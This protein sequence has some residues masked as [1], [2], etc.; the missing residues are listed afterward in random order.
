VRLWYDARDVPFLRE[1]EKDA[2]EIRQ[3]DAVTM[4]QLLDAGFTPESVTAAVIAEDFGILQHSN[5]Y[6]V[7]LQPPAPD[8]GAFGVLQTKALTISELVK[9]G[10]TPESVI[11]AVKA[12]DVTKLV[13]AD[14]VPR[15]LIEDPAVAGAEPGVQVLP[16]S[17]GN[18]KTPPTPP[19]LPAGKGKTP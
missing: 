12:N 1:D 2:A 17:D 19:A 15:Q 4:R 14:L 13:S 7:Q 5:L 8:A 16:G 11:E 18:G 6:S 9:A 10:Y 3:A